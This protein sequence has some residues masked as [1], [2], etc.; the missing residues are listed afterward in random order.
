VIIDGN[1]VVKFGCHLPLSVNTARYSNIGLRHTAALGL[2]ER[3]DAMCVVVSEEKGSISL[4]YMENLTVI[5]SA[6]ALHEALEQ[7]YIRNTPTKKSHPALNWLKENTAEKIIAIFIAFFLWFAFGYQRDI[8]RREF[9]VPIEYKNIPRNWQI[10]KTQTADIR[11]I[12]KGPQQAFYL[13]DER[14]LKLSLDLSDVVNKKREY[15]LTGNMLNVPSSLSIVDIVPSKIYVNASEKIPWTFPVHVKTQN[16]LSENLSLQKISVTPS[17][18]RVLIN[19]QDNPEFIRIET[20]PIDLAKIF[21]TTTVDTRLI[22][23]IGVSLPEG[24]SPN[25]SVLIKVKNKSP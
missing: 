11:V 23:P 9:I 18:I 22:L 5:A 13:F 25:A 15:S 4:A 1:R 7:F 14:T 17:K 10:E 24:Q 3:S 21:F 16:A 19:A 2:S 6:S 20:E 8:V 12:L